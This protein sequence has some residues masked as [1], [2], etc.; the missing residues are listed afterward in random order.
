MNLRLFELARKV[1]YRSP[2]R[3][4]LGAVITTKKNQVISVG[5]NNM[6]KTHPS[7]KHT[8]NNCLHA[9]IHALIGVDY[10]STKRGNA[11]VYRETKDGKLANSKPC[12]AC[13]Q[14]LKLAGIRNV[15]YSSIDGFKRE[16]L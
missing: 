2:S 3:F 14:A 11:Y 4:K 13:S 16:Q 12:P 7:C 8:Y 1:S 6:N 15:Y 5:F 9:E 10:E